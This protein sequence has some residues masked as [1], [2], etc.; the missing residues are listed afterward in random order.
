M[1]FALELVIYLNPKRTKNIQKSKF[2]QQNP[3]K[4]VKAL[5]ECEAEKQ[6]KFKKLDTLVPVNYVLS[7]PYHCDNKNIQ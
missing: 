5:N 4:T 2:Q 3:G 6:K 7:S 1:I